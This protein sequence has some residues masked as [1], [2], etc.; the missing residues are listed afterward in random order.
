MN[1]M[2]K[3]KIWKQICP[4]LDYFW[5]I[6]QRKNFNCIFLKKVKVKKTTYSTL[7]THTYVLAKYA[8]DAQS[9]HSSHTIFMWIDVY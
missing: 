2:L 6:G 9:T 4:T 5:D 1:K 3:I 8:E 7:F